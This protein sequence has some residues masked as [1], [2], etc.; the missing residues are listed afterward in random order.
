M[1]NSNNY[2]KPFSSIAISD[3]DNDFSRKSSPTIHVE[4]ESIDSMASSITYVTI[5]VDTNEEGNGNESYEVDQ[6][7]DSVDMVGLEEGDRESDAKE[8]VDENEGDDQQGESEES[9]C[10]HCDGIHSCRGERGGFRTRETGSDNPDWESPYGT[11]Q[12]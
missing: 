5:G 10:G 11:F 8:S 2:Q 1:F 7:S 12:G 6:G 9:D 4:N 3:A